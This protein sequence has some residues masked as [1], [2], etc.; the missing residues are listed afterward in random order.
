MYVK[1]LVYLLQNYAKPDD[2]VVFRSFYNF[3]QIKIDTDNV[4]FSLVQRRHSADG[5]SVAFIDITRQLEY[6]IRE[7]EGQ[8]LEGSNKKARTISHPGFSAVSNES[9]KKGGVPN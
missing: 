4:D 2:K 7:E 1:D 5:E 8:E 3:K 9:Q 6:F